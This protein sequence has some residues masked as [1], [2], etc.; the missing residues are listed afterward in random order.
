MNKE[1]FTHT[2]SNSTWWFIVI[3][4]RWY[5]FCDELRRAKFG[6]VGRRFPYTCYRY[7]GIYLSELVEIV[8]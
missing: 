8:V 5:N 4:D 3:W 6:T 2:F 7:G 1:V